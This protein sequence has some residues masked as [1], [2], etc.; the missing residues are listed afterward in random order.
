[1]FITQSQQLTPVQILERCHTEIMGRD[2]TQAYAG[3]IMVGASKIVDN[4]PTACTDGIDCLYGEKYF[5]GLINAQ[6]RGLIMHENLHKIYQHM[7]LWKHLREID[8]RLCN[9]ACDYVINLVIYDLYKE[10]SGFIEL[11]PGGLLDERFRGMDTQQVFK[12]LQSEQAQQQ[13]QQGQQG[14]PQQG[15]GQGQ[16]QPQQSQDQGSLDDHDWS[17]SDGMTDEDK[18]LIQKEI[19][20]AIR[21]G[22]LAAGKLGGKTP[23]ALAELTEPKVDWREQLREFVS[24]VT[25]GGDVGTWA[26]VSRRWLQHDVYMPSTIDETVGRVVIA[27]DTSGSVWEM[28]ESF[29][30]EIQSLVMTTKPEKVDLLYWDT[31]VTQHEVYTPDTY[32]KLVSN[33]KPAGGGGTNAACV[34]QYMQA[35]Q[36]R[37]VCAVVLT[38][39]HVSSWGT[40]TCPVLWCIVGGN[41]SIRPPVGKT[42]YID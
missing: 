3:V 18:D 21:Q 9:M 28:I 30:T 20:Q 7:F 36:I 19:D 26:K 29:M 12:I 33:T 8:A 22:I 37:P 34:P 16:G 4:V 5:M 1:M 40:W 38:D 41:K 11:P 27:A 39:G 31:R 10:T 17:R 32:D 23:R 42:I 35:N 6:R 25:T 15:Q 13:Q 24:S 2:E 14:Q